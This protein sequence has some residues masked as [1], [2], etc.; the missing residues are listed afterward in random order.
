MLSDEPNELSKR[1]EGC[2]EKSICA[3]CFAVVLGDFSR[4]F[5]R[6]LRLAREL[7]Q[8][9]QQ[10]CTS[11]T[12]S[13]TGDCQQLDLLG[14]ASSGSLSRLARR[15][16]CSHTALEADFNKRYSFRHPDPSPVSARTV[17]EA[18]P[19]LLGDEPREK[20]ELT[21]ARQGRPLDGCFTA[22]CSR[23]PS[24]RRTPNPSSPSCPNPPSTPLFGASGRTRPRRSQSQGSMVLVDDTHEEH[25][26]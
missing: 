14:A 3:A 10:R 22:C 17:S 5:P 6:S 23:S 4:P 20:P 26:F 12:P 15:F 7:L 25:A 1:D 24:A 11:C 8:F 9:H 13:A 21:R 16:S 2:R 18:L 19:R